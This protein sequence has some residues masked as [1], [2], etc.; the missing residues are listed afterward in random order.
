MRCR[1]W[2]QT[3]FSAHRLRNTSFS[4]ERCP[5]PSCHPKVVFSIDIRFSTLFHNLTWLDLP[6][7]DDS[8]TSAVG[9]SKYRASHSW[10]WSQRCQQQFPQWKLFL[11]EQR[12]GR[13]RRIL[14]MEGF[15][16]IF[17]VLRIFYYSEFS[18]MRTSLI[19]HFYDFDLT[20]LWF[21]L[22]WKSRYILIKF[23][24]NKFWRLSFISRIHCTIM[25]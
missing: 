16:A 10:R 19:W 14:L 12:T 21:K 24:I 23:N 9:D 13:G 25:S 5:M 8:L 11:G 4:S 3:N 2:H 17:C 18:I 7:S 20:L 6:C 15:L 22:T 1:C